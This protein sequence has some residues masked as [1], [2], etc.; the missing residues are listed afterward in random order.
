MR[1][2]IAGEV[3]S[4]HTARW[5]NQLKDT[6]WQVHLF[7]VNA[8]GNGVNPH[9]EYGV[10]H[11]PSL[12]NAQADVEVRLTTTST[13]K[14]KQNEITG[15]YAEHYRY[16]F[17]LIKTFRPH[18]LHSHGL[19]INWSNL[20]T[21]VASI[22]GNIENAC[23][24]PWLYSTWG[25]DLD[26]FAKQSSSQRLSVVNAIKQCD[27]LTTECNRDKR[28][29]L[30][31]G[32]AGEY[33][34]QFPDYGGVR[35]EEMALHRSEPVS[36]R[37]YVLIKGRDCQGPDGD[38]VGRAMVIMKALELCREQLQGYTVAISQATNAVSRYAQYLKTMGIN[39]EVLPHLKYSDLL[40]LLGNS[41]IFISMTINDGLPSSLVEA[42]ALGALPIHS[43][44]EPIREWIMNGFNGYL[45][46]PDNPQGLAEYLKMALKDDCFVDR[47]GQCN[48]DI[49]NERL[50]YDLIQR[51]VISLYEHIAGRGN[52]R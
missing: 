26:F 19:N 7:Q 30:E 28:L 52:N 38:P 27:Y 21:P 14:P 42:M 10:I 15:V 48:H 51:R 2:L 29:A 46:A 12:W 5:V 33:C 11:Y 44:L 41:R 6:G 34:G 39:V 43:D 17:N 1:V 20:L 4:S 8:N 16:L 13:D 23:R 40:D 50:A 3:S 47:A 18:V 32:F 24:P 22:L 25:T 31:M 35:M 37:K 9:F 45:V 49:I 36:G